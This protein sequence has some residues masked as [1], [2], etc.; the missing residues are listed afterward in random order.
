MSL[1]A[2]DEVAELLGH[3]RRRPAQLITATGPSVWY[4][5]VCQKSAISV[6]GLP[7][8][9]PSTMKASERSSDWYRY[10]AGYSPEF[11][12]GGRGADG[13]DYDAGKLGEAQFG[14]TNR[15]GCANPSV[16]LLVRIRG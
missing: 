2:A 4:A 15:V 5:Q 11:R 6:S 14:V 8:E 12:R 1:R 7:P 10:Y 9:A 13:A 16:M 3:G